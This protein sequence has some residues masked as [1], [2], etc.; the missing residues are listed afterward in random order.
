M[1]VDYNRNSDILLQRLTSEQADKLTSPIPYFIQ[2]S[3]FNPLI[4][5]KCLSLLVTSVESFVMALA[6][7]NRS[8]SSITLHSLYRAAF[9]LPNVS[10]IA[11][12]DSKTPNFSLS[13]LTAARFSFL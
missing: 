5:L 3:N 9:N 11:S 4:L 13:F 6:A 8:A 1:L 10:L 2:F 12:F 7:I